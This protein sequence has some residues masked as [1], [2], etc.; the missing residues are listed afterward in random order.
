MYDNNYFFQTIVCYSKH[1]FK[2]NRKSNDVKRY[3]NRL[4][5]KNYLRKN[6]KIGSK[7]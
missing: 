2:K 5:Q 3:K 4:S 1:P 7:N 6:T